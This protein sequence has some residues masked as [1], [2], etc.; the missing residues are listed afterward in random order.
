MISLRNWKGVLCALGFASS[1]FTTAAAGS[2]L[3]GDDGVSDHMA[4][5]NGIRIHYLQA[6]SGTKTVVL[7]HGWPESS[8]EFHKVIGDL[9]R[10]YTV[11]VPDL[12]GVGGTQ[13]TPD[14]YDKATMAGDTYQLIKTLGL[15]NVYVVG[16]DTGGMVAYAYL[17]L[18]P[19]EV[20]GIAI[21]DVPVP[22]IDPWDS[23]SSNPCCWHFQMHQAPGFA[24]AMVEGRQDIYFRHSYERFSATPGVITDADVAIYV[25]AYE[26]PESLHAGFEYFRAFAA[27]A[28][29][30][31]SHNDAI[32]APVLLV[33]GDHSMGPVLDTF[34]TSLKGL[35]ISSVKTVSVA[36]SGHWVAEEQP[37]ALETALR[38]FIGP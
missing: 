29:F 26:S 31:K 8:H 4:M 22:G 16:H 37:Q 28:A 3:A 33:G 2:A 1:A 10:D 11:I 7:L 18:H 14:G 25:K 6:G 9:A 21:I 5:A 30:N 12:R 24:E 36:N 17:R 23:I 35:G 13:S 27:D 15:K 38:D 34:A 20:A 19:T 32:A